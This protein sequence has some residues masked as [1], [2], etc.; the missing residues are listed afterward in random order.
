[1]V[2][3]PDYV[4]LGIVIALVFL[5][6]IIL[7]SASAPFSLKNFDTPYYFLNH[8]IIFGLLPGAVLAFCV[9]KM[10]LQKIKKIAPVLFLIN[11]T[12]LGII[13]LPGI[14]A[15]S[16]G[17][18]R[19]IKMGPI[20]FQPA[21]F[22]KLTF[23]LYLASW[24][25]NKTERTGKFLKNEDNSTQ[26]FIVFL[27]ILGLISLFLALQPDVSTLA[28]LAATAGIMYF[29]NQ[30][31]L[32]HSGLA[33]LAGAGSLAALVKF[34]PYRINRLLIFL[35]RNID[36]SG[37]GYQI[38]QSLIAVG[39]G[40]V[41]GRGFGMSGQKLGFLPQS[42]SDTIF[43]VF[44]EETG[45]AGGVILVLLL[46]LFLWFGFR[47]AKKSRN[48]FAKLAAIGIT[49]WISIQG[50]VNIGAMIGILPIAGIPLPFVSYGGS[51]LITEMIGAGLLL[52]ISK[53]S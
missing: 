35:N 11:L 47:I 50:F 24:L 26:T 22:L 53:S 15:E 51:A 5:G 23:I 32:R 45:F 8:Q 28:I 49:S 33:L 17:A 39:S 34:A 42:I 3:K 43:A 6:I 7:T 25:A 37:H 19:W 1:M 18:S 10:D 27:A 21:E 44:A 9:Y 41:W 38:D 20:S 29:L 2:K 52:N 16:G 46:A 40:G 31:P 36:P 12:L 14:G 13:F 30:T 4:F 48:K